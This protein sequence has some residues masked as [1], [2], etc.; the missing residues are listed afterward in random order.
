MKAALER[1]AKVCNLRR[2]VVTG[3]G[4]VS[5]LGSSVKESWDNLLAGKSGVIPLPVEKYGNIFQGKVPYAAPVSPRVYQSHKVH[6]RFFMYFL[7]K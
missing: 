7:K 5:S 2:V 1:R 6:V 3:M 4:C